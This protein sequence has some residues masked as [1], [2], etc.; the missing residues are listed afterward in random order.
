MEKNPSG[1]FDCCGT[2][3]PC[4]G[5]FL[6]SPHFP[7]GG[8]TGT[9]GVKEFFKVSLSYHNSAAALRNRAGMRHA[10]FLLE[11]GVIFITP[12]V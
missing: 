9:R 3:C 7:P 8:T 2:T 10:V 1:F 6:V 5:I 11:V 12:N 4:G